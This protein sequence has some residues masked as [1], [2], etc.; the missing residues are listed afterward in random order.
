MRCLFFALLLCGVA[1]TAMAQERG[2]IVILYDNDVHCAIDGY[3]VM[4]GLRDSLL[5]EG[6]H[7]M[8]VS[9]GDFSFGG[10][11]GAASKGEFIVR[12]MNA[13]GYDAA[14]LGN[15]EFDYGLPQLRRM[16]S[17]IT[18][19]LLCCNFKGTENYGGSRCAAANSQFSQ[20]PTPFLPFV[21]RSV[22]DMVVGFVGVTTPTTLY[23]STPVNFQNEEGEYV[24][25]F[26][27]SN[28]AGAVQRAVDGARIA[29]ADIVVLLSHTGDVDGIPTTRELIGGLRGV[30]VV[31]DGHDHHL[32]PSD[33]VA[34]MDDKPVLLSSTGAHFQNIGV[35]V[36]H[37]AALDSAGA[38]DSGYSS[39]SRYSG[40]SISSMDGCYSRLLSVDSLR[41][42]GVSNAAVGDTLAEVKRLFDAM[43]SNVV[44]QS[45][46]SLIAEEDGM[47]VCR[48]RETNLGDLVADAYRYG[49][50]ADIGWVN[51]GGIRAN[52]PIGPITQNQLFAVN[53]YSNAMC[54]IRVTGRDVLNALETAVREYPRAEGCFPQVSGLTFSFDTALPS[55]VVLDSNGTFLRVEGAYRVSRVMVGDKPLSLDETYTIAGSE[56]LMLNG[57]DAL[58]FPSRQLVSKEGYTDLYLLQ[59]YLEERLH[60]VVG[61]EYAVPQGR[62]AF[63]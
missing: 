11:V 51:G 4:A 50:N 60:G 23:T 48:L 62:I 8:V 46:V 35:L 15:H 43:G 6:C 30:D 42:A 34:D 27:A 7:T 40:D 56:Y 53:P 41:K 9:C 31:L 55:S 12:M 37:P 2:D 1:C 58:S 63:N 21:L 45:E 25:N 54:L 3:P 17:L 47:R 59:R 5:R 22:G 52:L 44:A 49:M 24:Y 26:S 10:P 36:I 28:L 61:G 57:G 39:D 38:G 32:L 14:C 20:L 16:E 13:V 18:A 29:G 33:W 19:P